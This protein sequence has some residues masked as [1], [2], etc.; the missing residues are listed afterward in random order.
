MKRLLLAL[1]LSFV[2][3]GGEHDSKEAKRQVAAEERE[4][5]A[6]DV[7]SESLASF[8]DLFDQLIPTLNPALP[9][10]P[11]EDASKEAR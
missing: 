6:E 7:T 5:A 8:T 1:V 9:R 3:L 4:P 10:S 2:V 11:G